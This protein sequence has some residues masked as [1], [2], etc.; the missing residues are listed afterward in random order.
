MWRRLRSP[1]LVVAGVAALMAVFDLRALVFVTN[2]E[3]RFP[4]LARDILARGD[5][6]FP[7]LN[8][9]VYQNKPLLLAWLIAAVSWPLGQVTAFTAVVP[10]IVASVALAL[11]VYR[12]GREMFGSIAGRYAGLV[13]ATSQGFVTHARLAMPDMLLTLFL[14]LALWQGWRLTRGRAWAWLGAYGAMAAAFWTKGIVGLLPLAILLAWA[15]VA[16][17]RRRLTQLRVPLGLPFLVAVIAPWPLIGALAHPTGLR[18]A[19]ANDHL[20][21]YLSRAAPHASTLLAPLQDAFGILFP[22]VLL[23]PL[24]VVAAMATLRGRGGERDS[25]ELLL[26]SM[27]VVFA[28]VALSAQQR[29]R[30]Y[31]PLLPPVALLMG[32]W[33]AGVVVRHRP[34]KQIPWA[35]YGALAAGLALAG[36][37]SV[38]RAEVRAD[39]VAAWRAWTLLLLALIAVSLF[40]AVI[41]A[42]TSGARRRSRT[43]ALA[44]A[45]AAIAAAGAYRIDT[46]RPTTEQVHRLQGR[47][48]PLA[49]DRP[50]VA[51][52][53]A[54]LPLSFYLGRPVLAVHSGEALAYALAHEAAVG[55]VGDR[56]IEQ[57]NPVD[58]A[59]VLGHV[60]LGVH[61]VT[62]LTQEP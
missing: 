2:D 13:V 61:E 4:L 22:W 58:G 1:A 19:L 39:L 7:E 6:W 42:L 15:C 12:A 52:D 62:V 55:V 50:V 51:W 11:I 48:E 37:A 41:V 35:V 59:A 34:V 32:W 54:E 5:I 45:I 36:A 8:G 3:A 24:V 27:A 53:V 20:A 40:A 49:V 16:D 31:L 18:T 30:Y 23:T 28:A 57:I 33:I 60:P 17:R 29:V 21:W 10:S 43:F 44:C 46:H 56:A 25:I 38:T 26:V 47:V 14:T 9:V